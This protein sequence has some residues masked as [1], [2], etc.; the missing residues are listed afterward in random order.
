[1]VGV[2][3]AA[4]GFSPLQAAVEHVDLGS[5]W[6]RSS[7]KAT[8]AGTLESWVQSIVGCMGVPADQASAVLASFHR[9]GKIQIAEQANGFLLLANA[10]T[11]VLIGGWNQAQ[12]VILS[13]Y[14][15]PTGTEW[16]SGQ[17]GPLW[18]INWKTPSDVRWT[19]DTLEIPKCSWQAGGDAIVLNMVWPSKSFEKGSASV[20]A[21]IHFP[22]DDSVPRFS[23]AVKN[24]A[25]SAGI[26]S[27]R[28]PMLS[29]VGR[30]GSVDAIAG[31][32]GT[33]RLIRRFQGEI[34]DHL[35][36]EQLRVLTQGESSLYIATEDPK[37]WQKYYRYK[38]GEGLDILVLPDD[39]AVPGKSYEQPFP[40]LVGPIK[41]DWFDATQRYR[42]WGLK[43]TWAKRG[44]VE[45][46]KGPGK[47]MGETMLWLQTLS[48]DANNVPKQ[49]DSLLALNQRLGVPTGVHYYQWWAK[50]AFSPTVLTAGFKA[51][52]PQGWDPLRKAGMEIL[53]Y[54]NVLYWKAGWRGEKKETE[55]PNVKEVDPGFATARVAAC[56]PYPGVEGDDSA[57]EKFAVYEDYYMVYGGNNVM[58]P[59]C[60]ETKLWQDHLLALARLMVE[61]GNDMVY[62]DQGGVPPRSPCF[63]PSHGHKLGGGGQWAEGTRKM[64][65]L[66]KFGTGRELAISCEGA[67]EGYLD[68]VENHFMHY[69][70]WLA[71]KD[72]LCPLFES[73]YHDYTL[74]MG[75]VK[76]HP[77][78]N[79]YAIDVGTRLL[80]GNQFRAEAKMFNN[81]KFA[82]QSAFVDR[83]AK[84]RKVG[85][86][87]LVAGRLVRP[88]NWQ[89][90]PARIRADWVIKNDQ[91]LQTISFPA[92]ERAAFRLGDGSEAL[93][94]VN[95][96]DQPSSAF[97]NLQEWASGAA[98]SVTY[99]DGSRAEA[100]PG[101]PIKV[102]ARD[103][104][105]IT[106]SK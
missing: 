21:E 49:V 87:Y 35:F 54:F 10:E 88:P 104:F 68:L 61:T 74:F 94:V 27:V 13:L 2:A 25:P 105:M 15:F 37:S 81:P 57:D 72:T 11:G 91:L 45:N 70:P 73:I 24:D 102:P 18:E 79:A 6:D 78:A 106:K 7:S 93:F 66:I 90:V 5:V 28:Y 55:W 47:K 75:A 89:E 3:L 9:E 31:T 101:T 103:G 62:L 97:L 80:F 32:L 41:G 19:N 51:G 59:M 34:V 30:K 76:P 43:Q 53:P 67:F 8:A 29:G 60:R 86:P 26:W 82:D 84:L 23:I 38:A 58:I 36:A 77:D 98:L 33:S 17:K 64:I 50:D 95:F 39:T 12:P 100:T 56:R 22:S 63:D 83:M 48:P 71:K 1:M 69:W 20:T 52:L 96:S 99:S 65:E 4:L 85:S 92:M 40:V 42:D 16:L 46:W 14:H 44:P